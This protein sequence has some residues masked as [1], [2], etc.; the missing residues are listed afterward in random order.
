MYM[1][2]MP[3]HV[4]RFYG[5]TDYA[6]ECIA[7]KQITFLHIEKLNDPFDPVLDYITD[8]D[9]SYSALLSHVQKHHSSQFEAFKERLPEQKWKKTIK[10]WSSLASAIRAKMFIF[11][12]CAVREESHPRANLYM[13]GHYGNGHRGAAIEFNTNVLSESVMKKDDPNGESS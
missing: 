10:D 6:L 7:L 8:F 1:H 5:N 12:T 4:L 3:Q 2:K 11:S 9:D 13:W